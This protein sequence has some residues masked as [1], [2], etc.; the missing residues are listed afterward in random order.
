MRRKA[1]IEWAGES[2]LLDLPFL[3][4]DMVNQRIDLNEAAHR[5]FVQ[6]RR[7]KH[8]DQAWIIHCALAVNDHKVPYL[9]V[10]EDVMADQ[11]GANEVVML[12]VSTALWGAPEEDSPGDGKKSGGKTSKKKSPSSRR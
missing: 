1:E 4:I 11:A 8:A 10:G 12:I 2:F 6:N 7:L 9:K 3:F 5:L